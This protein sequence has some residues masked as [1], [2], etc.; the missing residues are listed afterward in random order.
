MLSLGTGT[1]ERSE[2]L[3]QVFVKVYLRTLAALLACTM[4]CSAWARAQLVAERPNALTDVVLPATSSRLNRTVGI[5]VADTASPWGAA[6][7]AKDS[8]GSGYLQFGPY[9]EPRQLHPG[10][11]YQ[12]AFRLKVASTPSTAVL[13]TVDV[14]DTVAGV[15]VSRDLRR[16]D[17]TAP[18]TYQDVVLAFAT[19]DPVQGQLELRVFVQGVTW[20]YL[21]ESRLRTQAPQPADDYPLVVTTTQPT[22]RWRPMV[23]DGYRLRIHAVPLTRPDVYT[24]PPTHDSGLITGTEYTVPAGFLQ[25]EGHSRT[26]GLYHCFLHAISLS[27][28]QER[29]IGAPYVSQVMV[30]PQGEDCVLWI[31]PYYMPT[32]EFWGSD[33]N[34]VIEDVQDYEIDQ[35]HQPVLDVYLPNDPDYRYSFSDVSV[36]RRHFQLFPG[37]F[38]T[39]R[40]Y[41][42]SG[43]IELAG[44]YVQP[45]GHIPGGEAFV[46][47]GLY[48]QRYFEE[49]FNTRATVAMNV[50]SFGHTLQLPQLLARADYKYLL[51]KRPDTNYSGVDAHWEAPDGS[52]VFAHA[53]KG[54]D[55]GDWY[56]WASWIGQ[57]NDPMHFDA[58][59]Q[60]MYHY[61]MGLPDPNRTGFHVLAPH[62]GDYRPPKRYLTQLRNYWNALGLPL[63]VR[64]ARVSDFYRAVEADPRAANLPA[65]MGETHVENSWRGWVAARPRSKRENRACEMLLM[66]AE[67]WSAVADWLGLGAPVET[68]DEA[69]RTVLRFQEHDQLPGSVPDR[70]A[71]QAFDAYR[72][73]T[74]QV[75]EIRNSAQRFIAERVHTGAVAGETEATHAL[76]VFNPLSWERTELVTLPLSEAG[77]L[78]PFKITDAYGG[79]VPYQL[80]AAGTMADPNAP[81][82]LVFVATVPPLGY[83]TYVVT[84]GAVPTFNPHETS[85]AGSMLGSDR[86]TARLDARGNLTSL[87][88]LENTGRAVLKPG[89][90]GNE[91]FMLYE[92]Q[93]D[94][95]ARGDWGASVR[96]AGSTGADGPDGAYESTAITVYRGPVLERAV[97]EGN[98]V[99]TRLSLRAYHVRREV[100]FVQGMRR[101]DF[102]T[103]AFL[104]PDGTYYAIFADPAE[105]MNWGDEYPGDLVV[106]FPL[107]GTHNAVTCEVAYGFIQRNDNTTASVT[108]LRNSMAVQN[109]LAYDFAGDGSYGTG[110]LNRGIP[111]QFY[112]RG[113]L[114][115]VLLYSAGKHYHQGG[116]GNPGTG[117]TFNVP[118]ALEP[119]AHLLHYALLPYRGD[120][121]SAKVYREGWNRNNPLTVQRVPLHE[122][123]LPARHGFVA[124][125]QRLNLTVLRRTQQGYEARLAESEGRVG[126]EALMFHLPQGLTLAEAHATNFLGDVEQPLSVTDSAMSLSPRTQEIV[127]V[128]FTVDGVQ[129]IVEPQPPSPTPTPRVEV[130]HRW[131]FDS[132]GNFEGWWSNWVNVEQESV[133]NG[134]LS[135]VAYT[136]DPYGYSPQLNLKPLASHEV[137]VRMRTPDEAGAVQC[138]W[139]DGSNHYFQQIALAADDGWHVYRFQVGRRADWMQRPS[140]RSIRVD[141]RSKPGPF[142]IDY[143]EIVDIDPPPPPASNIL[144]VW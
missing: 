49:H 131:D 20:V 112:Y 35:I 4:L 127:T 92:R 62:G 15:L 43:H 12:A 143:I 8:Y 107:H 117:S 99:D 108:A 129:T 51:F 2:S 38:A 40:G 126:N 7:L 14:H 29:T 95:Y 26:A 96:L 52:R 137:R 16:T 109:W 93:P 25:P 83:S 55:W 122:G 116:G 39:C 61:G 84:A 136:N 70:V 115:M 44:F 41:V 74:R 65:V 72:L 134:A 54:S 75:T 120:W 124:S 50:D 78:P 22:F 128:S 19:P 133:Q 135:G 111:D 6:M 90:L 1:A 81:T 60:N 87:T 125:T 31:V 82:V 5:P 144:Q 10:K 30:L 76:L 24:A 97:V 101:I 80:F 3:R 67:K 64:L 138:Y 79:E 100:R 139:Q 21:A 56:T 28:G 121:K 141:P 88:D 130:V 86:Y 104:D 77:V 23:A 118:K 102:D 113:D 68:L 57:F 33:G 37:D 46:R 140:I 132:A 114:R 106:S 73:V 27:G 58:A 53:T 18:D 110:L 48:A 123:V 32:H 85:D 142:D 42:Q 63:K 11:N 105:P 91:L 66:E 34:H 119:G 98:L 45:D 13:L 59:V 17:F 36:L 71:D 47:Q 9:L 103:W 69:W 89:R 94:V